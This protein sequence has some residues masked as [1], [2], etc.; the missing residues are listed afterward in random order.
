MFDFIEQLRRTRRFARCV[1]VFG[2]HCAHVAR[3][4]EHVFLDRR[5]CIEVEVLRQPADECAAFAG[6]GSAIG[7]QFTSGDF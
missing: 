6:D 3:S 7:F 2:E 5:R 1:F 4:V